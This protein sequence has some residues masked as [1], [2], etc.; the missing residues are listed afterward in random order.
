MRRRIAPHSSCG[1]EPDEQ[2]PTYGLRKRIAHH[3]VSGGKSF[4]DA[5]RHQSLPKRH[6]RTPTLTRAQSSSLRGSAK[7]ETKKRLGQRWT[8]KDKDTKRPKRTPAFTRAGTW[9]S[10]IPRAPG[11]RRA[12]MRRM[13]DCTPRHLNLQRA[14]LQHQFECHE[15]P[16]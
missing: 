9:S 5:S 11:L 3:M 13:F 7:K 14:L 6:K 10:A 2:L 15:Q 8:R 1:A 16:L 4:E 12:G